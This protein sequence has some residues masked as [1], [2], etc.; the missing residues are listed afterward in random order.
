VETT[1]ELT[2]VAVSVAGSR[3][4]MASS[5]HESDVLLHCDCNFF[6]ANTRLGES[7]HPLALNV[8][9]YFYPTYCPHSATL[10]KLGVSPYI[11][12]VRGDVSEN[13]CGHALS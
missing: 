5:G 3:R 10:P 13:L 11:F 9:G 4:R 8:L 1:R 2:A 12:L 6:L 7:A